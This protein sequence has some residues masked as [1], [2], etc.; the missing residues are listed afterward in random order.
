LQRQYCRK[1]KS[2]KIKNAANDS[3]SF[4]FSSIVA[5]NNLGKHLDYLD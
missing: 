1:I 2:L 3:V 4:K 5:N